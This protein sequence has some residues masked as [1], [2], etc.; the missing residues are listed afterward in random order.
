MNNAN[1]PFD[2]QQLTETF[3]WHKKLQK[4]GISD[5]PAEHIQAF[6][7]QCIKANKVNFCL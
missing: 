5:A 3:I 4:Q 1:H 7:A 6:T 2:D